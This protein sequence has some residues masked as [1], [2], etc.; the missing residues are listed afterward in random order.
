MYIC[1]GHNEGTIMARMK[2]RKEVRS[3]LVGNISRIKAESSVTLLIQF[4]YSSISDDSAVENFPLKELK[5]LSPM[6]TK[7]VTGCIRNVSL[8]ND[9]SYEWRLCQI[10]FINQEV[11]S[12][13][14]SI[15]EDTTIVDRKQIPFNKF[16]PTLRSGEWSDIGGRR[17]MKDT[18]IC[19]T[20]MA[21]NFGHSICGEESISF[22]G[23][24][25]G[26]G[27]KG[28]VLFVRDC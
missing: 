14:G 2:G 27:G 8:I 23:V 19:I 22:Y 3:Y 26:H 1:L 7:G 6:P 25:D 9:G 20:D 11:L 10:R 18:H 12:K 17:D 4:L 15:S 5:K 21:K 13:M 16:L 28:A 24:F